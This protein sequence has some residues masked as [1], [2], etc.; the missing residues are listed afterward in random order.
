M[1]GNW[2]VG[3]EREREDLDKNKWE[4]YWE[5]NLQLDGI[6]YYDI[7]KNGI[8]VSVMIAVR[9]HRNTPKPLHCFLLRTKYK[10]I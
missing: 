7:F 8:Q 6:E 9:Y 4:V 5:R 3:I 2:T 10:Y 1:G